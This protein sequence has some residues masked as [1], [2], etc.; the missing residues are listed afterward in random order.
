MHPLRGK[1]TGSQCP[2][3]QHR[4]K[5]NA[6][7][8]AEKAGIEQRHFPS[9]ITFI[10]APDKQNKKKKKK[11]KKKLAIQRLSIKCLKKKATAIMQAQKNTS[12][13]SFIFLAALQ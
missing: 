12:F 7:L 4:G 5:S 1:T 2:C 9:T 11:K 10:T 8:L 3:T 13:S 6:K